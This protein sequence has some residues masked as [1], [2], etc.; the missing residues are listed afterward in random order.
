MA[1]YEYFVAR[2]E[3]ML[4][5]DVAK[6][7]ASDINPLGESVQLL[8]LELQFCRRDS[9]LKRSLRIPVSGDFVL[10]H[11]GTVAGYSEIRALESVGQVLIERK[12]GQKAVAAFYVDVDVWQGLQ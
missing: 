1:R 2:E 9:F 7:R 11:K 12:A 4:V 3:H 6:L 8:L 10:R 5:L